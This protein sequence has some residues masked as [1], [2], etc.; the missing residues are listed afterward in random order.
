MAKVIRYF[1]TTSAGA[2]DGTSW[3]NRASLFSAGAWSTIIT[4]FSFGGSDSLECRIGPGTYSITVALSGLSITAGNK[5]I[6]HGCDSSGELLIPPYGWSSA[7]GR[8][9]D[10]LY[11]IL[12]TSTN[13]NTINTAAILRCLK[14]EASGLT[15][16]ACVNSTRE[17]AFCS[18]NLAGTG[19]VS[20]NAINAPSAFSNLV[21]SSLTSFGYAFNTGSASRTI[22]NRVEMVG[23]GSGSG[24]K[25]GLGANS[26]N[27]NSVIIANTVIGFAGEGIRMTAGFTV[28]TNNIVDN[29]LV[30]DCGSHGIYA[31]HSAEPTTGS[32]TYRIT[33]N[34]VSGCGGYGILSGLNF[35]TSSNNRLRDNISGSISGLE[36]AYDNNTSAGTDADEFVN[37][38]SGDYRIK[39][40]SA[41]WGLG[42]GAGD[43]PSSG[44]GSS[45]I[46]IGRLISGGV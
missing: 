36:A 9:D 39:A 14:F 24:L 12:S 25:V 8:F 38:A 34:Y 2:G 30:L 3:A 19:G 31:G 20:S 22:N 6:I 18:F 17:I 29:N 11:P 44:G 7:S 43:E 26:I 4:G 40:G 46:P 1:S 32:S 28:G 21:L 16:N 33:S 13:I 15:T 23:G 45:G 35:P 41:I 27:Y 5:C 42:I 37:S 10:S